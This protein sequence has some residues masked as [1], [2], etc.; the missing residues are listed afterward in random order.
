MADEAKNLPQQFR[1]NHPLVGRVT[2]VTTDLSNENGKMLSINWTKGDYTIEICDPVTGVVHPAS[3]SC[4]NEFHPAVSRISKTA[5][6]G[7]F[8]WQTQR[9]DWDD[10][11]LVDWKTITYEDCKQL[12]QSVPAHYAE[13][14]R[15]FGRVLLNGQLGLWP[16]RKAKKAHNKFSML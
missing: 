16:D 3:R 6:L 7:L 1:C 13:A 5:F 4:F 10:T 2:T 9:M 14:R 15:F 8:K 12:A 11:K